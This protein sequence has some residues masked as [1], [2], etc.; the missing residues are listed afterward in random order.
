MTTEDLRKKWLKHWHEMIDSEL[1]ADPGFKFKAAYKNPSD[2]FR[3]HFQ[4]WDLTDETLKKCFEILPFG[5]Q[6]VAR[7]IEMRQLI[8]SSKILSEESAIE[9]YELALNA[10]RRLSSE[11]ELNNS[12]RVVRVSDD[13]FIERCTHCDSVSVVLESVNWGLRA[14]VH[15]K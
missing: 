13:E 14:T 3:M 15:F 5:E 1:G 6:M 4:T 12:M 9:H 2:D 7:A 8:R 11:E 10:M